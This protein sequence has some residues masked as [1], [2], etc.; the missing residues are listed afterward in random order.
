MLYFDSIN[1]KILYIKYLNLYK[2]QPLKYS[3]YGLWSF[4]LPSFSN[5]IQFPTRYPL[6]KSIKSICHRLIDVKNRKKKNQI[7][8]KTHSASNFPFPDFC[9]LLNTQKDQKVARF[10][11]YNTFS[12][13]YCYIYYI[14]KIQHISNSESENNNIFRVW[15]SKLRFFLVRHVSNYFYISCT[16]VSGLGK[17]NFMG[18]NK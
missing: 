12:H 14:S 18:K 5:P 1:K 16:S 17:T 4:K 6:M 10:N 9:Y 15:K 8:V 7:S 2:S 13:A 11:Y 3:Y